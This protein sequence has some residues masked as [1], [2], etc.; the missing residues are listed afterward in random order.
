M[1]FTIYYCYL[2]VHLTNHDTGKASDNEIQTQ[3]NAAIDACMYIYHRK[4]EGVTLIATCF[5]CIFS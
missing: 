5:F 2:H 4:A 1:A 3:I